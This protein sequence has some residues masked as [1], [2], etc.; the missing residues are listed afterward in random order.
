MTSQY[1]GQKALVLTDMASQLLSPTFN[2]YNFR[3]LYDCALLG[4]TMVKKLMFGGHMLAAKEKF[5]TKSCHT[6]DTIMDIIV[7]TKILFL[8]D[9]FFHLDVLPLFWSLK[10]LLVFIFL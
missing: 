2:I 5:S 1:F 6:P 4:S 9:F 3:V 10:S 8:V 7:I